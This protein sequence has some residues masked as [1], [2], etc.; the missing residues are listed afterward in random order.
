MPKYETRSVPNDK[1]MLYLV[2][3]LFWNIRL[4]SILNR[5]R[6]WL[7]EIKTVRKSID[8][9]PVVRVRASIQH[10]GSRVTSL[11]I[12][13]LHISMNIPKDIW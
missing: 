11:K 2:S 10:S 5:W 12:P 13:Q 4:E 9:A 1:F 3:I 6:T 7:I 8:R